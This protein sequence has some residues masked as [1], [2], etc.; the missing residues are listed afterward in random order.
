MKPMVEIRDLSKLFGKHK[1]LADVTLDVGAGEVLSIVGPSGAGKSTLLRC[2]NFLEE[3]DE[4]TVSVDGVQVGYTTNAAGRR[5]KQSE[6]EVAALRRKVGMVFQSFNLFGHC[7]AIGNVALGP[8]RVLGLSKIEAR[9]IALSQLEKVGLADRGSYLPSQLSGGQQ[10]RVA[11]ARALAMQPSVLLLDEIT[12]ALD[13]EL[14]GEVLSVVRRLSYEGLTMLIVTHEMGFARD[15]SSRVAFMESG[16]IEYLGSPSEIFGA[17][18]PLR[19]QE[20]LSRHRNGAGH[21]GR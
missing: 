11:I 8:M 18:G 15:V 3:F 5:V 17:T 1:V 2:V 12:S 20:F 4:G 10:Q 6:R 14:V 21:D 7:S 13:P 19:V 9:D 16:Q